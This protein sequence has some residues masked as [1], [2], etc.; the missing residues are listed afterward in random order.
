[1]SIFSLIYGSN[2]RLAGAIGAIEPIPLAD[3]L[4]WMYQV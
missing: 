4:R 1:M 3:T 2:A